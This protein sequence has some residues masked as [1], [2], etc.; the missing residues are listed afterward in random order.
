MPRPGL[1]MMLSSSLAIAGTLTE[2]VGAAGLDPSLTERVLSWR[3]DFHEHPELSNREFRTSGIVAEHLRELGLEVRTEVAHTGVVGVLRGAL[4]GPVVG[5][6]AD[7]DALPV[8]EE[9]GLPFASQVRTTYLGR[10]VGVMHACGHDAHTA[11]LMGVAEV[12]ADQRETLPGTVIFLFQPAEE[13]APPGEKGG[14]RLMIAEGALED[15]RPEVIFGLHVFPQ[16]AAGEI[17]VASGGAMA[18]SDRLHI[19]VKG[20]QT[21]AAYPWLGVDPIAVASRIVLALQAIPARQIDV[22]HPSVISI[23]AIHGG[24]RHNIIP[25][26]V[27]LLGTIRTLDPS[28]QEALHQRIRET[29]QHIAESAGASAEVEIRIGYPVT[30]NDPE[31]ARRMRPTLERVAGPDAVVVGLPR[32]GAEDFSFL[33]R[34]APGLY[35]FLG[36]RPPAQEKSEAAPNH[37]PRFRVDESAL[38]LGVE[39]LSQLTLDYLRGD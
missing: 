31:L 3:R 27:E 26:E 22:R 12:L 19:R 35:L 10:E 14:A 16:Y 20:R 13:G 23:G 4:P 6:R 33:A 11:I 2:P 29:A 28:E 17:A 37:S 21:H 8:T 1:A 25:D 5:L 34:E 15:P 9:T 38:P 18:S 36:V 24:V 39:A 32:T 7:M 30:W